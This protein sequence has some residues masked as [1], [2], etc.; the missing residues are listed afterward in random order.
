MAPMQNPLKP[1]LTRA[2]K[3]RD[4]A[5]GFVGW[6]VI[7]SAAWWIATQTHSGTYGGSG[8]FNLLISAAI[9]MSLN[10]V[11]WYPYFVPYR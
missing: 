2:E 5:I 7:N 10:G 1:P 4:F 11:C 3:I 8:S 6:W 9:G